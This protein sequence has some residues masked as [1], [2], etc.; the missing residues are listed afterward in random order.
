M[1]NN[2]ARRIRSNDA[3]SMQMTNQYKTPWPELLNM[4]LQPALEILRKKMPNHKL[5]AYPVHQGQCFPNQP[6]TSTTVSGVI[7]VFYDRPS[8]RVSKIEMDDTPQS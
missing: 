7:H 4:D 2:D 1:K 3:P 6:T 5:H 8:G